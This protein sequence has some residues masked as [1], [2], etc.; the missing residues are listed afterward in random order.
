MSVQIGAKPLADFDRPLEMLADCHRRVEHFLD[1]LIRVEALY[2]GK[3][4]DKQAILA[5]KAAQLY[6]Q[7]SAP[8][9]TADEEESL[10]PRMRA[11]LPTGDLALETLQKL[12]AD[13]LFANQLHWRVERFIDGWCTAPALPPAIDRAAQFH[14]D[15][16]VLKQHY[17]EHIHLEE[18]A[19]FPQAAR[20]LSSELIAEIGNEMRQRRHN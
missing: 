7:T 6:F 12:E 11:Q 10:F 14:N 20:C 1:V 5:L 4:L 18:Q 16:Q 9:H 2:R 19:V 8:K 17:E 15:L 13:H 3:P